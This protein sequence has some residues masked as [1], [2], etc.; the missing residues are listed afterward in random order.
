MKRQTGRVASGG[1]AIACVIS[2][3]MLILSLLMRGIG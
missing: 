3:G 2:L 1:L